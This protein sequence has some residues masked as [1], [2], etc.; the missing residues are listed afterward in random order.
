MKY[1]VRI[2]MKNYVG[3]LVGKFDNHDVAERHFNE[4]V[5]ELYKEGLIDF[6]PD[7]IKVEVGKG[8]ER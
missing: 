7:S 8:D 1:Y 4:R 2:E 5:K 3:F 6:L